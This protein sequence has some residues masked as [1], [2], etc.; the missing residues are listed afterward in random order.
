MVCVILNQASTH[1]L[2][3]LCNASRPQPLSPMYPFKSHLVPPG[4]ANT[5]WICHK[6]TQHHHTKLIQAVRSRQAS[7]G[8]RSLLNRRFRTGPGFTRG[9]RK[10]N[11]HEISTYVRKTTA[12]STPPPPPCLQ[13]LL[14]LRGHLGTAVP[15]FERV[16][17]SLQPRSKLVGPFERQLVLSPVPSLL[18]RSIFRDFRFVHQG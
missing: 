2:R 10:L 4:K 17:F 15:C 18:Q 3:S 7:S 12:K 5:H 16:K 1:V 8:W 14:L 11:L 9:S 6:K 13:P